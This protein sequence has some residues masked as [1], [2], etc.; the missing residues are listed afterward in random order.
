MA[1]F[2]KKCN[3]YTPIPLK[4]LENLAVQIDFGRPNAEIGRKVATGRL[5]ASSLKSLNHFAHSCLNN[6][7]S[8]V[9]FLAAFNCASMC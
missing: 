5:L 8:I 6:E 7:S 4:C 9:P 3:F 2:L 1:I